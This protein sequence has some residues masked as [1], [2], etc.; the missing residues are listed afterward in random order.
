MLIL[1]NSDNQFNGDFIDY[2]KITRFK[3]EPRKDCEDFYDLK[4]SIFTPLRELEFIIL[5]KITFGEYA[6]ILQHM[7]KYKNEYDIFIPAVKLGSMRRKGFS[8]QLLNLEKEYNDEKISNFVRKVFDEIQPSLY[9][10]YTNPEFFKLL[11][12]KYADIEEYKI[13]KFIYNH[14]DN[15]ELS[16]KTLEEYKKGKYGSYKFE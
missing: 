14:N 13:L 16:C 7:E 1:T 15:H 6:N 8:G 9:Q 10:M 3:I 2:D 11:D 12:E 5:H 4:A